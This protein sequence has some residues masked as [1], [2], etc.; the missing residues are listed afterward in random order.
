MSRGKSLLLTLFLSMLLILT[1]ACNS[2]TNTNTQPKNGTMDG[3]SSSSTATVIPT[4][5]SGSAPLSN[6]TVTVIGNTDLP[7]QVFR[8]MVK[9]KMENVL[10]NSK[11]MTLYYDV[12]DT[13]TSVCTDRCAWDW[14]PLL[15]QSGLP[16]SVV[17]LPGK[18]GILK[19]ANGRQVTYNGHPLYIFAVDSG[20][21]QT[22]GEGEEGDWHVA[23]TALK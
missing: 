19:D 21:H 16:T 15:V 14:P 1:A 23:T 11:G 18:L 8:M 17:P 22:T 12:D 4:S 2:T 9:G 20:P 5:V 3:T 13:P 10:T 6:S 7:V